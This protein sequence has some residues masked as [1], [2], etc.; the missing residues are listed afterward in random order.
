MCVH[1]PLLVTPGQ[2]PVQHLLPS[3]HLVQALF[4]YP[5]P[6]YPG[7]GPVHLSLLSLHLV[8][9]LFTFPYPPHT[10]FRPCSLSPAIITAHALF[11]FPYPLYTW[12]RPCV[13]SL[14]LLTPGSGPVNL[15]LPSSYQVQALFTPTYWSNLVH[16]PDPVHLPLLSFLVML[17]II[18]YHLPNE[19]EFK[20]FTSL[21]KN[22]AGLQLVLGR[23]LRQ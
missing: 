16:D 18:L 10:W 11:T 4:T 6:P 21:N 19:K 22:K 13:P 2:G 20:R 9:A 7:P 15:P 23:S 17:C 5:Y 8:Q 3:S 1:L 12:F 14:T